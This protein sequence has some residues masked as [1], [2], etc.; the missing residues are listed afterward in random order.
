MG[1]DT[2]WIVLADASRARFFEVLDSGT[3]VAAAMAHPQ[4]SP[5]RPSRAIASDRPGRT[6][7][8]PGPGDSGGL[9]RH[10]KEPRTDPARYEEERFAREVAEHLD[11]ER[12]RNSFDHLIIVAPPRFLGDL[13]SAMPSPLAQCVMREIDKD[14]SKLKAHELGN[15][16]NSILRG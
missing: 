8:R 16:L 14:L 4:I 11:D 7:D 13:R 5:H 15:R 1:K 2:T 10:A 3:G 6:F 9:G 12:K